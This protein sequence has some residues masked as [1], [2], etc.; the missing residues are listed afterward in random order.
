MLRPT[1]RST[2]TYSMTARNFPAYDSDREQLPRRCCG[3]SGNPVTTQVGDQVSQFESTSMPLHSRLRLKPQLIPLWHGYCPGSS[4]QHTI[5][6]A[7][8]LAVKLVVA[9]ARNDAR[10]AHEAA[11]SREFSPRKN[12][13]E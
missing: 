8:S 13:S 10:D 11:N 12:G 6:L 2:S 5:H 4:W 3:Q 1:S 9:P 7:M